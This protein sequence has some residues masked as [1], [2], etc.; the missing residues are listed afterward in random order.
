MTR[1]QDD[2]LAC[3]VYRS[4]DYAVLCV[5][6]QLLQLFEPTRD[7]PALLY[8]FGRYAETI[9]KANCYIE[10]MFEEFEGVRIPHGAQD[11]E[12]SSIN[13]RFTNWHICGKF[14]QFTIAAPPQKVSET[15]FEPLHILFCEKS[16]ALY[17]FLQALA[18]FCRLCSTVMALQHGADRLLH[19]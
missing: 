3:N 15:L 16:D 7:E 13:E 2:P 5:V 10:S 14:K 8:K 11:D 6:Q 4:E 19:S 17:I 12:V 1:L 18:P 9:D